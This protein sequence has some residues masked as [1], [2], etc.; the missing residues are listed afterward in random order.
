[1]RLEIGCPLCSI[2]R[3]TS[4]AG[5]AQP[6]CQS[7]RPQFCLCGCHLYQGKPSPVTKQAFIVSHHKTKR[8]FEYTTRQHQ[9]HEVK[10]RKPRNLFTD[11]PC[12]NTFIGTQTRSNLQLFFYHWYAPSIVEPRLKITSAPTKYTQHLLQT[13]RAGRAELPW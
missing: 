2:C 1:M 10:P 12:F 6:I 7:I 11:A 9:P 3:Y 8:R 5:F 4:P 13:Q